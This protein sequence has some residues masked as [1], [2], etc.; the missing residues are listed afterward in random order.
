M[1]AENLARATVLENHHTIPV[2]GTSGL[3]ITIF[4]EVVVTSVCNGQIRAAGVNST[5]ENSLQYCSVQEFSAP[6]G[7]VFLPY[8]LMHNLH[9]PEGGS[10]V[11]S[12]V[13]D[14]PRGFTVD[15][16]QKP[17]A[18][19]IWLQR[20]ALRYYFIHHRLQIVADWLRNLTHTT[21]VVAVDGDCSSTIL[22]FECEFNNCH[23]VWQCAVLRPSRRT[24]TSGGG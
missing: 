1:F 13:T 9:V 17:R 24:E 16:S 4:G 7:Q 21:L 22:R 6:E 23:R 3:H 5:E 11:V 15:C 8:W 18:F 20:L 10:V 2:H 14:L 12:S 19:W